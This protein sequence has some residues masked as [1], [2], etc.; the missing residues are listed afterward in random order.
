M[1]K[2]GHV[3]KILVRTWCRSEE[4]RELVTNTYEVQGIDTRNICESNDVLCKCQFLTGDIIEGE[5]NSFPVSEDYVGPTILF[6]EALNV[7]EAYAKFGMHALY[8]AVKDGAQ[9]FCVSSCDGR[10][11]PMEIGEMTEDEYIKFLRKHPEIPE[12]VLSSINGNSLSG[13]RVYS[14]RHPK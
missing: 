1:E 13:G 8:K 4:S 2:I 12:E 10:P 14:D 6:G 5:D 3:K 11:I 7:E 9:R